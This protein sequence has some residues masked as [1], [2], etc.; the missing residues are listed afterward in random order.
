MGKPLRILLVEDH[1]DTQVMM[2]K[3]LVAFGHGVTATGT[4]G[5]ALAAAGGS[6]FDLVISDL[7]LPDG[8]GIDLMR[9]LRIQYGLKGI[10]LTGYE[11]DGDFAPAQQAGFVARLIKPVSFEQ[12]QKVIC[13][14]SG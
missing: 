14:I 10:A 5:D 8:S 11:A 4:V 2:S 1:P 12:L 7:G 6:R 13:Q 3:L 9:Q